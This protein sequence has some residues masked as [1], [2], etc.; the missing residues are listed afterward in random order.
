MY[1]VQLINTRI[2]QVDNRSQHLFSTLRGIHKLQCATYMFDT[3]YY[4]PVYMNMYYIYTGTVLT[5]QKLI[6][7]C[8]ATP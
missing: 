3:K 7:K 4:I 8:T 5:S 2:S 6:N 1:T